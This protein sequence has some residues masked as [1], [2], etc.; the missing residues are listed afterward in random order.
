MINID[1]LDIKS[2][3]FDDL[4]DSLD[5]TYEKPKKE[6]VIKKCIDCDSENIHFDDTLSNIV[7]ED[8]ALSME[9]RLDSNPDWNSI[10]SSEDNNSRCGCPT[11]YF[12]PNS[13][14]GCKVESSGRY[15]KIAMLERWNNMI[16]KERAKWDVFKY[17]DKKCNEAKVPKPIIDNAKNL[18]NTLSKVTD[19][20]SDKTIIIRG[21]N[22]K[23]IIAACVFNGCKL[24][25]YPRTPD[26][27]AKIFD[28]SSKQIT[29]G[30]RKF[31]D[32][33]KNQSII[34]TVKSTQSEQFLNRD[35]HSKLLKLDKT[36]IDVAKNIARN[37]TK[38]DIASDHQPASIAA[39]SIMLMADIFNLNISKKIIS[40]VY[41]ISQVTIVKAYRK[42]CPFKKIVISNKATNKLLQISAQN[43]KERSELNNSDT[44]EGI[45][46]DDSE[47]TLSEI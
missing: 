35:E 34:N 19:D 29:K 26:E 14:L 43:N 28:I 5:E 10:N 45:I 24:Q 36:H 3:D 22:R 21:L 33:M 8:C 17:I 2:D 27:I 25:G 30:N 18:F 38:L 32:I 41:G 6:A 23:S 31:Q 7:C 40:D 42:I 46:N 4:L 39:S 11:N 12:F 1:N 37:V 20:H 9:Y 47:S 15:S 16:Y 44:S 13:S